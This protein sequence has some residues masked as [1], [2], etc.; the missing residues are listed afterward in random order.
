MLRRIA[1]QIARAESCQKLHGQG[2]GSQ[3][4]QDVAHVVLD[5]VERVF[6]NLLPRGV[7]QPGTRHL[8]YARSHD[9]GTLRIGSSR[10][11]MIFFSTGIGA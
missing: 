5:D 9:P 1:S 11:C 6:E 4:D 2:D 10:Y 8:L 7:G 3:R